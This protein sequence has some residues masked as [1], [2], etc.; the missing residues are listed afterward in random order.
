[1]LN[2]VFV[3]FILYLCRPLLFAT[4]LCMYRISHY[5]SLLYIYFAFSKC[6]V[7]YPISKMIFRVAPFIKFRNQT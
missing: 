5:K 6:K 2:Y 4:T 3:F 7:Q 1:M